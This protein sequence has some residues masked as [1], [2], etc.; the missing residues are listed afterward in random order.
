MIAIGEMR[1][2]RWRDQEGA[3][4]GQATVVHG[5]RGRYLPIGKIAYEHP[6]PRVQQRCWFLWLLSQG[7][8]LNQSCQ[9]A[10]VSRIAGWRY[11]EV[12][13]DKGL[14]GVI[15]MRWEGP[16]SGLTPHC[17]TLESSFP[18]AA[19]AHGSRSRRAHRATDRRASRPDPSASISPGDVGVEL[20][21]H[22]R[23][24][25][26]APKNV[27]EHVRAQAEFLSTS[28]SH[29][30]RRREPASEK[31]SSSTRRTSCWGRSCVGCGARRGCL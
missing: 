18:G 12:Y 6:H 21:T 31:C 25:L 8:S 3:K 1:W 10:G 2:S 24:S 22:G 5:A 11:G 30:W 23:H 19:A 9:L 13:R 7:L 29:D 27:A 4:D 16:E 28:W 26:P 17:E 15:A 14:E 20:A